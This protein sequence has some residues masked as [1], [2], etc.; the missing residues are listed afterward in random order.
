M[1][2]IKGRY[3]WLIVLFAAGGLLWLFSLSVKE[4]AADIP[5]GGRLGVDRDQQIVRVSMVSA[6]GSA[7]NLYEGADEVWLLEGG[8]VANM[9]AVRELKT[10]LHRLMV[11]RP[12]P[13]TMTGELLEV[14]REQGTRVDVYTAS[15]WISLPGVVRWLPRQK[16]ALSFVVGPDSEDNQATYVLERGSDKAFEVY[17]P[18]FGGGISKHFDPGPHTWLDP[19]VVQLHPSDIKRVHIHWP[20]EPEESFTMKHMANGHKF[21]FIDHEGRPVD[22][23]HIDSLRQQY[24]VRAFTRLAYQRLLPGSGDAPPPDLYSPS[25]F[26]MIEVRD[27]SGR[28][29]TIECYKRQAVKD[30]SLQSDHINWDP[31]RFYLRQD[32][33]DFAM[34]RFFFWQPV[35]RRL[36]YFH[37]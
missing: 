19:A 28:T 24:F 17:V 18:G 25:P 3:G 23:A 31:N 35:M 4:R 22:A 9:A 30:G 34:A 32:E 6:D 15:H 13:R 26:L 7:V 1:M 20:E 29:T 5:P 10:V 37:P 8:E 33:G 14:I 12:V 2:Q 36:S 16:M 21:A 27:H 11:R